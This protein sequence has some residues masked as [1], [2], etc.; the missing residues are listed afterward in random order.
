MDSRE[1]AIELAI[2]ALDT[3][4][5]ATVAAA[6]REYGIPRTTLASR[7]QGH[8]TQQTSHQHQQRLTPAQEEF[9][10]DWILEEDA[11]GAP[12][13]HTRAREM[14]IQVLRMNGDTAPLGK[15]WIQHFIQRNPHI[16]LIVG[17]KIKASRAEAASPEQIQA[18]LKLFDETQEQLCVYTE[19]IWNMDETG[20]GLGLCTN[21]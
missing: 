11:H 14:A 12:P 13:S 3:K 8:Q 15:A 2:Q 20:I 17:R 19:N 5:I 18:F 1:T 4:E 6:A 7:L 21:T 16:S 10:A 9:L